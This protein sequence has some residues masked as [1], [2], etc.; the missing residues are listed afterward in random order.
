MQYAIDEFLFTKDD[1]WGH[2]SPMYHLVDIFAVYSITHVNGKHMFINKFDIESTIEL[3]QK[4]T[5]T[6]IASSLCQLLI[7]YIDTFDTRIKFNLR[8]FSCGGSTLSEIYIKKV[9]EY[10]D[11]KFFMSYGMTECCG[12]IS[13]SLVNNILDKSTEDELKYIRTSGRPFKN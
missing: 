1:I 10:F 11:C 8:L 9:L 6:N 13:I 7:N 5:V 4:I 3:L 2:I 12:K